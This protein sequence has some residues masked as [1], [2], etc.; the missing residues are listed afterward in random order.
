MSIVTPL[1]YN[2]N[3][4]NN[5][6]MPDT[7]FLLSV[8]IVTEVNRIPYAQLTLVDGSASGD[9]LFNASDNVFFNPGKKITIKLVEPSEAPAAQAPAPQPAPASKETVFTGLVFGH[10]MEAGNDR[11]VLTVELKDVAIKLTQTPKSVV[12]DKKKDSDV[13]KKLIKNYNIPDLCAGSIAETPDLEAIVQYGCTD[14]DFI[15]S[16]ADVNGLLVC[17]DNGTLSLNKIEPPVPPAKQEGVFE[18]GKSEIYAIEIETNALGQYEEVEAYS[19]DVKGQALSEHQIAKDDKL[20]DVAH[21]D[22]WLKPLGV[23][24]MKLTSPAPITSDELKNWAVASLARSRLSLI[25]GRISVP[26]CATLKLLDAIEIKDVGNHFNGK[27]RVTGLR[28]RVT[29]Q[30]WV[31]DIRFG[32]PADWFSSRTDVAAKPAAGLLPPVSGLQVGVVGEFMKDAEGQYRV[33]VKIPSLDPNMPIWARLASLDAGKG[34]GFCF[35]PEKGDEVVLGFFNE[36]PRHPVIIGALHS[37]ANTLPERFATL[38]EKN[39]LKGLVT[40]KGTIIGFD[41]QDDGNASVYIE[42]ANKNKILLDDA[43]KTISLADQHGNVITL[44]EHGITIKSAKDITLEAGGKLGMKC[45]GDAQMDSGGKV[46]IIGSAVN[47]K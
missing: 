27:S 33:K 42:T 29:A 7:F 22:N 17:V 34:R 45:N 31:T 8:D 32:L 11:S 36:D 16:R 10:S 19:W 47:M 37:S 44:D 18:Y 13:I 9:K 15:V 6:K 40:K 35:R 5:N 39:A 14:W 41:E 24:T 2:A 4:P 30:G 38:S 12:F 28:H 1:I 26:G 21:L 3:D 46:E 23:K 25:R 43:K 20:L